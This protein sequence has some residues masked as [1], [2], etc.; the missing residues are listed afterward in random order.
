MNQA[1]TALKTHI[2]WKMERNDVWKGKSIDGSSHEII[3]TKEKKFNIYVKRNNRKII[4][5]CKF[6]DNE[7]NAWKYFYQYISQSTFR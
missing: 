5:Q 7:K 4:S 3:F 1:L 2:D 6:V